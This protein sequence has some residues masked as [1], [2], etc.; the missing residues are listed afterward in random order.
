M[1]AGGDGDSDAEVG[2]GVDIVVVAG[3]SGTEDGGRTFVATGCCRGVVS[4]AGV[5]ELLDI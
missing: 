4:T 5:V 2:T 1:V 3:A